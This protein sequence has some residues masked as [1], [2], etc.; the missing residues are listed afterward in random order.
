MEASSSSI[1]TKYCGICFS[2]I[3]ALTTDIKY[4]TRRPTNHRV[5]HE[6]HLTLTH[7]AI[8]HQLSFLAAS[9]LWYSQEHLFGLLSTIRN[10]AIRS[11]VLLHTR[12]ISRSNRHIRPPMHSSVNHRIPIRVF[13]DQSKRPIVETP[14]ND[15][16]I[17]RTGIVLTSSSP[18]NSIFGSM[19]V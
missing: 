18:G 11:A 9:S 3:K 1:G 7:T 8:P 16:S 17:F 13:R 6:D 2:G 12:P 14:N 4:S 5:T 15:I 19:V 10:T